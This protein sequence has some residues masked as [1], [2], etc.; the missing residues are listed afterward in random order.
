[1]FFARNPLLVRSLPGGFLLD[2]FGPQP[3]GLLQIENGE[4]RRG[5]KQSDG[6]KDELS[7][8]DRKTGKRKRAD[9]R[10]L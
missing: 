4:K 2:D 1:L 6:G 9:E 8:C 10:I 7:G 5:P 3:T